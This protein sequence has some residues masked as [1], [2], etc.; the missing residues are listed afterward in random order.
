MDKSEDSWVFFG[1]AICAEDPACEIPQAALN[2]PNLMHKII[3]SLESGK[4][5]P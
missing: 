3:S 5:H 4:S 1:K 2:K